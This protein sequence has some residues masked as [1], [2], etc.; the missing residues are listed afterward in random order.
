MKL[1]VC[2]LF[3]TILFVQTALTQ[4]PP[5][6]PGDPI[7]AIQG[8]VGRI[9]GQDWVDRFSYVVLTPAS[10]GM[11]QFEVGT[12]NKVSRPVFRGNNGVA[13]AL[14]FN[15]YLKYY[16]NCSISWGRNGT[17]DQLN[18][19]NPL[20]LPSKD[21]TIVLPNKYRY[22]CCDSYRLPLHVV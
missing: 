4:L 11:D 20:P 9:L 18:M 7:K 14:A 22:G 12:D 5:T 17:G 3:F 15:Y 16:C 8:L 2:S 19:P 6:P 13:L 10:N 21:V 1:H